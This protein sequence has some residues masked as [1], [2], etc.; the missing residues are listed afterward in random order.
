M[1]QKHYVRCGLAAMLGLSAFA[2][3]P[4]PPPP[5]GAAANVFMAAQ[6][7]RFHMV[8]SEPAFLGPPV[9]GA[10]YSAEAVTS[11]VRLLGDGTRIEN[12][13]Q[14]KLYRDSEGRTRQEQSLPILAGLVSGDSEPELRISIGDPVREKSILLNPTDK[15][16]VELPLPPRPPLPPLPAGVAPAAAETITFTT[17]TDGVDA[18]LAPLEVGELSVAGAVVPSPPP[19]PPPIGPRADFIRRAGRTGLAV[20][21]PDN[22]VSQDLGA[23]QIQ[24][25]VA[26]GTRRTITIPQG[27]IGNDRDIVSTTEE[28]FSDELKLVLKRVTKDPQIGEITYELKHLSR[29]EP[30]PALFQVPSDY[31]VREAPIRRRLAPPSPDRP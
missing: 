25:V 18:T 7:A 6:P 14:T 11:S 17:T 3:V 24:G 28:W 5:P 23:Q 26:K 13:H 15:S 31:T 22:V 21:I 2:Q 4:S 30:D 1:N 10:P 29:A 19:P 16:A 12:T 8:T 27:R 9:T 20:A